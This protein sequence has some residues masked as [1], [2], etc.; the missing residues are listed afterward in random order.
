MRIGVA[1]GIVLLFNNAIGPGAPQTAPLFQAAGWVPTTLAF[2][3][4][5]GLSGVASLFVCEAM[6]AVPGNRRF[7]ARVEWSTLVH[8][9][10][11]SA[12]LSQWTQLWLYGT[13]IGNVVASLVQS[14]HTWDHV[15][16][17]VV[18]ATCGLGWPLSSSSSSS[19]PWLSSRTPASSPAPWPSWLSWPETVCVAN[20]TSQTLS[21]FEDV[22][23]IGTT[24][25]L[26]VVILVVPLTMKADLGETLFVQKA[27]FGITLLVFVQWIWVSLRHGVAWER[28]PAF[29]PAATD[30]RGVHG[31][32]DDL[33]SVLG[34]I[35]LNFAS[36]STV[37]AWVNA[38]APHASIHATIG[39]SVVL[40][41]ATYLLIGL[42]PALAF[43][44]PPGTTVL[45][46]LASDPTCRAV[47]YVFALVVLMASVPV[48][49]L[50]ARDNLLE[51]DAVASTARATW[52][53]HVLPWLLV[54][55]FQSGG[56]VVTLNAWSGLLFASITNFV[57]PFSIFRASHAFR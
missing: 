36:I 13:L 14:A 7:G 29:G 3:L 4:Y 6:Q 53:T 44:F 26:A 24:G 48:F 10:T 32:G 46:V 51:T 39:G 25:L 34:V 27:A 22:R 2:A 33:G 45:S 41:F 11:P 19:S 1:G 35:M 37:P 50:I 47:G 23:L 9:Y 52:L 28:V 56:A 8:F 15:L 40:C 20:H 54:L 43:A 17:D 12:R 21:P 38:R 30:L 5:A 18:G 55:P 16:I 49:M 31:G 57:L 42:I